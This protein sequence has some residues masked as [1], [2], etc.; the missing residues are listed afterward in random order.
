[1]RKWTPPAQVGDQAELAPSRGFAYIREKRTGRMWKL[2]WRNAFQ[3][4][5]QEDKDII[6]RLEGKDGETFYFDAEEL[7]Y[8]L[9]YV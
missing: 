1:M 7:R 9:K 8:W 5:T 6:V 4:K 3:V 2:I